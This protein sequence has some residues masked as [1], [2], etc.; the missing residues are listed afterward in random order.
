M[1]Y[2]TVGNHN[3][4]FDRLIAEIDRL[5]PELGETVIQTGCSNYKLVNA[6]SRSYFPF[7]EAEKMVKRAKLVVGHAGIG[8]IISARKWKTPLII[9]PRRKKFGEHINDHQMEICKELEKKP[10]YG[11]LVAYEPDD[12]E[13]CAL[14]ILNEEADS[15]ENG[16]EEPGLELKKALKKILETI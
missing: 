8:T 12:I 1:I 9:C 13:R 4:P 15:P 10:R 3:Q 11:V 5:A 14:K 2:V 16:Y 7:D 6:K